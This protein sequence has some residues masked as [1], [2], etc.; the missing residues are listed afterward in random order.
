M[1]PKLSASPLAQS[2]EFAHTT[3]IRRRSLINSNGRQRF[4]Q[5]RSIFY[6]SR[7]PLKAINPKRKH[8]KHQKRC[9]VRPKSDIQRILRVTR[10]LP[11][12]RLLPRIRELESIIITTSPYCVPEFPSTTSANFSVSSSSS[13]SLSSSM[14]CPKRHEPAMC[15]LGNVGRFARSYA[16]VPSSTR[17]RSI[18]HRGFVTRPRR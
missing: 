5:F 11:S 2:G 12:I 13:S 1:L 17:R 9:F 4:L 18:L 10:V 16:L 7:V 14:L 8:T 6:S 15:A 3:Q